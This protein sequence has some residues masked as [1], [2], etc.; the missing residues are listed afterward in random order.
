MKSRL[1]AMDGGMTNSA[2]TGW[3]PVRDLASPS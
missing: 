3:S 1:A 2:A